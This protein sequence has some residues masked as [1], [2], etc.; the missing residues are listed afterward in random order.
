MAYYSIARPPHTPELTAWWQNGFSTDEVYRIRTLGDRLISE[1]GTDGKVGTGKVSDIRRTTVTWFGLDDDTRWLYD[2]L[3]YIARMLNGEF[4]GFDIDGFSED[5]QYGV[6]NS[7]VEGHYGWHM[8]GGPS[9]SHK[10]TTP[11]RKLSLV[12]QLSPPDEYEG[13]DLQILTGAQ[14]ETIKREMG[15]VYAFPSYVLHQVT[16]VTRGT[17]RSVVVWLSGPR[18]R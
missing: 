17:R 13:G 11:P 15:L 9:S 4:F 14:P 8:D 3:A 2:R 12:L 18:W 5:I 7:E 10:H 16:P 1:R 6:Y